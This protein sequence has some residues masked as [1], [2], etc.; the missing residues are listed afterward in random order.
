[1]ASRVPASVSLFRGSVQTTTFLIAL[2][3]AF[4]LFSAHLTQAQTFTVLH[5]FSGPDG[6]YPYS[7]VTIDG[8]GNLYGTTSRGGNSQDGTAY[9]LKRSGS[10]YVLKVLHVFA[11]GSDGASPYAPMVYGPNGT[12]YGTTSLGGGS[13]NNGTIF[14]VQPPATICKTVLCPWNESVL[15]DFQ[16]AEGAN[17]AYGGLLF[18]QSGNMYGTTQ[19][20]GSTNNGA[21]YK[22][23][24]QGQQWTQ[25]MLHSFG[26]GQTDG[27][28]PMHNVVADR[29][30][31]LYGTTYQGGTNGGGTVF[32]L[33]PSGSGWT[34]NIIA[35]FPAGAEPQ[36]GL[37]IDSAG[38]LY[39][40]T[41]GVSGSTASQVFELSPSGSS[42]QLT[43]L[44]SFTTN[45]FDFGPVGN[46][47]MDRNGNLYG[48]TY[49]LGSHGQGNVFEL[50]P[51]ANGWT[52]TDLHDFTGSNDGGGPIGDLTVD[53][54]GNVY[55]TTQNGGS[56]MG[57]VWEFTP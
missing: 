55:G 26:S 19:Y 41:S 6:E 24:L 30:G 53:T 42:W 16:S 39:G 13:G 50:S 14:N 4:T 37:I 28:W 47:A 36:A 21:V 8:A 56:G 51:S 22:A 54:N 46:L 15:L 48:A 34:E 44:Q 20:G 35:N 5:S 2:L 40:A 3:F 43:V 49:S 9:E 1:M 7:G 38:N 31:N 23:S 45:R 12:L 29:L 27:V 10:A 57:V 52:Y 32:Q 18:D 25:T 33:V 17:P 11:G